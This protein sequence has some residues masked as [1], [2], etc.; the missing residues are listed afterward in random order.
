MSIKFDQNTAKILDQLYQSKDAQKRRQAVLDALQ[1]QTGEQVL[2][3]GTGLGHLALE[4]ADLAGP[5][6]KILGMDLNEPMLELARSRCDAKPWIEF[7]A[8][9]ATQLPFKDERFDAAVSVQVYEYISDT[10][11]VL[12]EL[13]RILKPGG[14]AVIVASDWKSTIWHSTDQVRMDKVLSVWEEHCAYSDLPRTLGKQL[15]EAGFNIQAQNIIQQFNPT[16]NTD[17][18]SYHAIN[19]IKSFISDRGGISKEEA[20][21]WAKDLIQ[22]GERNEYF[23]CL[24]QFLFSVS[25]ED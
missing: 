20:D 8:G 14:R 23:F 16:L 1:V 9:D 17:A 24:N 19:F 15:R 13:N 3:I 2:D 6:G 10:Y 25:K 11:Q 21:L 22:L 7:K 4:M 5:E 18:Y 12:K